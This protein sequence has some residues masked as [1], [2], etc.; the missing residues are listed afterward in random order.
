[1][2]TKFYVKKNPISVLQNFSEEAYSALLL[3][4]II[5]G[6]NPLS[7]SP[8][9]TAICPINPRFLPQVRTRTNKSFGKLR[10][11]PNKDVENA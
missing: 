10:F 9:R 2:R 5:V 11:P 3:N 7:V 4:G 1:L 8:S 6:M